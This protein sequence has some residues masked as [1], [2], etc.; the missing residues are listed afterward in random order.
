MSKECVCVTAIQYLSMNTMAMVLGCSGHVTLM[1][2][3]TSFLIVT[4]AMVLG[5]YGHVTLMSLGT[6]F[7]F[8]TMAMVL[9]CY[10]CH[11]AVICVKQH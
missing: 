7:L 8:I 6:P 2:L 5:C 11:V 3:G 9:G 4:M 10:M 1:S